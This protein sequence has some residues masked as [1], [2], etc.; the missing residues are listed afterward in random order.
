MV[1]NVAVIW[2]VLAVE[3]IEAGALARAIGPNQC[4]DFA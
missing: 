1:G 3:H 2:G 4:Q